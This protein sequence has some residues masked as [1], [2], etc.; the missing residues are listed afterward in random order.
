MGL[1]LDD[2][3]IKIILVGE[4]AVGKTS[5]ITRY[6]DKSIM[7]D[8][9]SPTIG[10]DLKISRHKIE[11]KNLKCHIWDTAGQD[12]FETIVTTYFKGVGGVICMFDVTRPTSLERAKEWIKKVKLQNNA[13]VLPVML[14]A[15]KIDKEH[16]MKTVIDAKNIATLNE[17]NYKEISVKNN[18]YVDDAYEGFIHYIYESVIKKNIPSPGIRTVVDN[19]KVRLISNEKSDGSGM[20]KCCRVS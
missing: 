10:V 11:G 8:F 6:C 9:H 1:Y 4:C 17:W 5:F 3:V 7:E 2:V 20:F 15:N 19:D 18:M 16:T 12:N 14:L 13:E